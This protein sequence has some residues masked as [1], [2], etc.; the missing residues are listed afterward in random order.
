MLYSITSKRCCRQLLPNKSDFLGKLQVGD[1][2]V[3]K[4]ITPCQYQTLFLTIKCK[5]A[6]PMENSIVNTV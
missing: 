3:R 4:H 2:F 1:I 6:I 5:A